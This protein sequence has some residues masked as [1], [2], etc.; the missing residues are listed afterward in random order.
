MGHKIDNHA[1]RLAKIETVQQSHT[2][3]LRR[4]A[5]SQE[6]ATSAIVRMER[7]RDDMRELREKH[8]AEVMTLNNGIDTL[9]RECEQ[10]SKDTAREREAIRL[11]MRDLQA[12][13]WYIVTAASLVGAVIGFLMG[14]V[15][16]FLL[17]ALVA[18]GA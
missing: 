16:K 9:R 1:E 6:T 2:E 18:G 11:D 8:D 5:E 13:V 4:I 12:R 10:N 17:P 15:T 3:L 14:L 7:F